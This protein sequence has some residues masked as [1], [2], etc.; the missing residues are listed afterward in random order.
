MLRSHLDQLLNGASRAL[1]VVAH[2]DDETIGAGA[3]LARLPDARVLHITDGA[4]RDPQFIAGG[5]SGSREEYAAARRQ[6]LVAAMALIG[7]GTERLLL[8]SGIADQ[9]AALALV[10]ISREVAALCR[11]LRP[12]LLL[13]HAYEGGHPDHDAAAFACRA[14]VELLRR[15]GEEPPAVVEMPFYH[16]RPGA[17]SAEDMVIQELLPTPDEVE[18][19]K[20]DLTLAERE[21][22]ERMAACF[23][24]QLG[25]VRWFLPA[26]HETFR[27]APAWDFTRPP[28]AGSLLYELWG[29]PITGERW[30]ELARQATAE[31]GLGDSSF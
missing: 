27:V 5:F 29:F 13:T 19:R 1:L 17:T 31:L 21:L 7:L 4:P 8:L 25:I 22:K 10:R 9:E 20:V 2:P 16:A 28:H 12:E 11:E 30:R 14:A 15:D 26:V 6:E 18:T 3:L 23:T 24:T